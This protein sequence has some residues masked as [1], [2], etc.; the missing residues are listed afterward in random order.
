[1]FFNDQTPL[2]HREIDVVALAAGGRANK[3][4]ARE[5]NISVFTVKNHMS[6]A[7]A[8]LGVSSRTGAA[9][10]ALRSGLIV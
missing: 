1:V 6:I 9:V 10:A 4:I 7:M 3:E 2:T 8:K 5:L